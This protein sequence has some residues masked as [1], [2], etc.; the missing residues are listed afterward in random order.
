V[1]SSENVIGGPFHIVAASVA[2]ANISEVVET[3]DKLPHDTEDPPGIGD[4][5]LSLVP[6]FLGLR[7]I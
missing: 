4:Q 6:P 2:I 7:T 1:L 3:P 5:Y